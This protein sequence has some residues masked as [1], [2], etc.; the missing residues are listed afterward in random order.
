MLEVH[1]VDDADR[2]GGQEVA[3]DDAHGGVGHRR[4]GQAL[5]ERSLDLEAQLA[6]GFLSAVQR[7]GVGDA[8][9]VRCKRGVWPLASELLVDLRPESHARGRS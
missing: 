3:G 6:G 7:D 2:A 4:V 8:A 1:T 9:A 5:A